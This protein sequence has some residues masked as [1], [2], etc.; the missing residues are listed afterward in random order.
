MILFWEFK[1][2]PACFL[3]IPT[4]KD[5]L[6]DLVSYAMGKLRSE[7]VTLFVQVVLSS[8][9]LHTAVKFFKPQKK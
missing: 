8:L 4:L 7:R 1:E 5:H 9:D 6:S 2:I 3:E